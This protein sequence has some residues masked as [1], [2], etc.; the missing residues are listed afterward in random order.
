M[1]LWRHISFLQAIANVSI[2][3][4]LQTLYSAQIQ[5]NK[6]HLMIKVKMILTDSDGYR[7][8]SKVTKILQ[9]VT[10]CKLLQYTH[11]HTTWY[12]DKLQ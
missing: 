9:N 4:N 8:R 3:L 1:L 5:Q 11:R 12:Q 10:P 2:L 6:V 7:W